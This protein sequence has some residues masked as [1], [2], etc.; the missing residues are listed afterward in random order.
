MNSV[1]TY[2]LH[3]KCIADLRDLWIG[4]EN[5]Y[6]KIYR[7]LSKYYLR[8]YYLSTIFSSKVR[9]LSKH[10]KYYKKFMRSVDEP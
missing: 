1:T 5:K 10:L 2:Q 3:M 7:I 4:K 6:A 9:Y 8:K